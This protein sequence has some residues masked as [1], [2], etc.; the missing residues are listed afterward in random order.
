MARKKYSARFKAQAALEAVKNDATIA[1][2]SKKYD[3]HP[4]QIQVWKNELIS[5]SESLFLK[6]SQREE[7]NESRLAELERKIGQLTVENDFLKKGLSKY[8]KRN[9]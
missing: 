6:S 8:P 2:L 5:R 9:A 3:V 1:E 4:T 7:G